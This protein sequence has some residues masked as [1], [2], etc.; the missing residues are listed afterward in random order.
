[1]TMNR[2]WKHWIAVVVVVGSAAL[3]RAELAHYDVFV[4]GTGPGSK[5]ILG[6]YEDTVPAATVPAGQ[7]RVFG[8]EVVGTG[9]AVPYET[10]APGEPGF[11]AGN[12][13]FLSGTS[14]SPS[15]VYTALAPS[16]PLT[17]TVQPITIGA[18]TRNLFFWDG[19]GAVNFAPVGG[20]VTL[21]L[22]RYGGGGWT[23]SVSGTSAGVQSGNTIANTGT[24]GALHAHL[25]TSIAKDG[26]APD[27][28]FYLLSLQLA[29]SGYSPSDPLYYV[30]GALDPTALAPQF[31]DLAA[32]EA[33]HGIAESW[34]ETNIVNVPEPAT[35]VLALSLAIAAWVSRRGRPFA[36]CPF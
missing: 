26:A 22:T 11:G 16:T 20:N 34:V 8:G 25:Y 36:R 35:G 30:F 12:Q 15:G 14:T 23:V 5:L 28:G 17:F 21:G 18:T 6:G 3:A 2:D 9:T 27:Q 13:A 29:M 32:F 19:S 33:A 24:G 4:T 1:M 31:A 7:M 10:E